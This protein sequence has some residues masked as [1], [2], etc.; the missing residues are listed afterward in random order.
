MVDLKYNSEL[1]Q[2]FSISHFSKIANQNNTEFLKKLYSKSG[3]SSQLSSVSTVQQSLTRL[4]KHLSVNYRTEYI[5]K[6]VIANEILLLKHGLKSSTILTEFRAI[7]SKADLVII[8]GTSS[9]YEVKSELDSLDKLQKQLNSYSLLFDN[10]Y[11]VIH[12]KF[13]EKVKTIVPPHVGIILLSENLKLNEIKTAKSNK[14][15]ICAEKVFESLRKTEYEQII[16]KE[17]GDLPQLPNTKMFSKCKELFVKMP[18]DKVHKHFIEVLK[19]RN[20]YECQMKLVNK[21]PKSLKHL[22]LQKKLSKNDCEKI[23]IYLEAK[24]K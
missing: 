21:S 13:L 5:Y 24:I 14:A 22:L 8:N 7:D 3:F 4:Y 23:G 16:K 10:I 12:P 15:N 17:I 9:V 18:L 1:S 20:I 6:N 11:V 2:L 19:N